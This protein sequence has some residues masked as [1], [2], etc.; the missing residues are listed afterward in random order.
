MDQEEEEKEEEKEDQWFACLAKQNAKASLT[1]AGLWESCA[2]F[3]FF[4]FRQ[5]MALAAH[6]W[7][8]RISFFFFF[9]FFLFFAS[10]FDID[11]FDSQ[12]D[13][14]L[15][16]HYFKDILKELSLGECVGVGDPVVFTYFFSPFSISFPFFLLCVGLLWSS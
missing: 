12:R 13:V 14:F 7:K 2:I 6:S 9:F 4:F 11:L 3:H 5:I 16:G 8:E 10:V 15:D 1:F